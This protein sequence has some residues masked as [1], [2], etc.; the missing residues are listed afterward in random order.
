MSKPREAFIIDKVARTA[1]GSDTWAVV[2][3]RHATR[4]TPMQIVAKNWPVDHH[5]SIVPG[6][7]FTAAL[8]EENGKY[9]RQ[10]HAEDISP[11]DPLGH[12]VCQNIRGHSP[13]LTKLS[14]LLHRFDRGLYNALVSVV[15]KTKPIEHLGLKNK[16]QAQLYVDAFVAR[17]SCIDIGVEYP[18][19]PSEVLA[20]LQ[21]ASVEQIRKNPYVLAHVKC[22]GHNMLCKADQVAQIILPRVGATAPRMAPSGALADLRTKRVNPENQISASVGEKML[23]PVLLPTAP[24]AAPIR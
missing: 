6:M 16:K 13:K 24:Y 1:P 23:V 15:E 21:D 8:T 4:Q 10:Y 12:L 18:M 7:T 5:N 20:R 19:I 22:R 11:D 9:G 14:D 2:K 3:A 17:R